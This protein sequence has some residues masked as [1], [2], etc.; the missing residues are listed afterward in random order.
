MLNI[1]DSKIYVD[2]TSNALVEFGTIKYP[3]KSLRAALA[4]V[5]N[6]LPYNIHEFTILIKENTVLV[7]GTKSRNLLI[8]NAHKLILR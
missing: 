5:Y 3:Y 7:I 8:Y 1:L 4:E 2:S 6:S